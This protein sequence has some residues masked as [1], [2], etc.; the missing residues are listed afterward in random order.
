MQKYDKGSKWMIQHHGDSIVRLAG[1]RDIAA[2]KPLQAELV[3]N[4]RMPDGLIEVWRHGESEPDL[5]VLE[6]ST[7]PYARLSQQAVNAATMVYLDREFLPEVVTL[8]LHPR[9][10]AKAADQVTL[11]SRL[12][13]TNLRLSW[14]AVKLW[15][16]HAEKL[17][18][19]GDVG[20]IPWVPLARFEG[21]PEPIFRECRKR[22]ER[23]APPAEHENLLAVL[24]VL[25]GLKYND[26][27][28]FQMLGGRETMI[29]SPIL[30]ELRAQWTRE[31]ALDARR[32]DI[33]RILR[34]R[35]GVSAQELEPVLK[36]IDEAQL[37]DLL[38]LAVTCRSLASFRKKLSPGSQ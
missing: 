14:K 33:A 17:L 21:R 24:H 35:F 16:I 3:Q 20:L 36:E 25:A 38:D 10:N 12:R 15:T 22:I 8:F 37:D 11:Q 2:W 5:F 34:A 28:L 29:E 32:A 18:A 30:Q 7:Y 4:R 31:G 9:G 23:D 19:A 13:L 27:R 26:S 6:I 1:V